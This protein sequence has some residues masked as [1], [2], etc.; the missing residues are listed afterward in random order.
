MV[1]TPSA[2]KR[3]TYNVGIDFSS[4]GGKTWRGPLLVT[5]AQGVAFPPL[6]FGPF[7]CYQNTT[8]RDGIPNSFGVGQQL[9]AQGSYP[10]YLAYEAYDGAA[11]VTNV[12]LTASYDGGKTWS[13]AVR[14]N[15][16]T[17]AVDEFQ[18][19][20]AVSA[21]TGT[22][23]VAFYDRRWVCP[24]AGTDEATN[25][26]SRSTSRIRGTPSRRPTTPTTIASIPA[27]SS[28]VPPWS[29]REPTCA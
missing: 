27:F 18:P 15:D 22:V 1:E 19:S 3:L 29:R 11:G 17:S 28:S 21:A 4:D 12:L 24:D 20:L 13:P 10:L 2:Q 26:V 25:A 8:F 14:V 9:S 6:C 7:G 16:N 23:S 5:S